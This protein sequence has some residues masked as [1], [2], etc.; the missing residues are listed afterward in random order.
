M[1]FG[2]SVSLRYALCPDGTL[3]SVVDVGSGIH[4]AINGEIRAGNVRGLWTGD[5]RHQRGDL[6]NAPIAVERCGGLLRHR[7]LARRGIQI[8]VD[9]TWLD[10]IDRDTPARD[11]SGQPLT[12]HLH[13]TLRGRVGYQPP[14]TRTRS[15]TDEPIMMMRPPGFM[16]LSAACVATSVPR[17][18][19]SITRSISSS[20]VSSKVF[21]MAVPALFTSTSSRPKVATVFSTASLTASTS[22]ASAWIATAFPPLSSIALTTAEAALASKDP[23]EPALSDPGSSDG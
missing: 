23:T 7:P 19:M 15:P 21:G 6:I 3:W 2:P 22:A 9:R 1:S 17:T 18:L 12:E 14:G 11:F 8:R 13:G 5:E 16:C 4:P 10:V 20:V